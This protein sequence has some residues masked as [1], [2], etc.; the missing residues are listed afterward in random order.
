MK[1]LLVI[2][3]VIS[4][5]VAMM[6]SASAADTGTGLVGFYKFDGNLKNEV[7]KDGEAIGQKFGTPKGDPV[8]AD[9]RFQTTTDVSDGAKFEVDIEKNF[10]V[11]F[12]VTSNFT[13][14]APIV[15]I[16]GQDQST[17]SWMGVWCDPGNNW[18][19]AETAKLTMSSNGT[20]RMTVDSGRPAPAFPIEN[21]Y[22]T[23]TYDDGVAS[24]YIDGV[25]VGS[26]NTTGYHH[27]WEGGQQDLETP[28][29]NPWA[30]KEDC[31]VYF[32]VNYWD[33]AAN[34]SYDN[35]TIYNRALSAEDVAALYAAGGV[36]EIDEGSSDEGP[37]QTGFAT[38]AIAVAAVA[39]GAYIV[40]KKRR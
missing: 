18:G 9:G 28:F 21:L 35:L 17:E 6:V 39:S 34:A 31:A 16:G 27:E 4:L 7:G 37:A 36:P 22:I 8:F 2:V 10:T 20:G 13:N 29:P 25:L 5:A 32:G 38:V 1:K 11:A 26:S 14:V 23:V 15:W 33:A 40:S 19:N 3:M 30:D 24:L 12:Y